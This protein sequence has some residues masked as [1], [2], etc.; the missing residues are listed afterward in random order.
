MKSCKNTSKICQK[1]LGVSI[2]L[3]I[4]RKT[5]KGLCE[6]FRKGLFCHTQE[7]LRE[8]FLILCYCFLIL[9][10]EIVS[11]TFSPIALSND[12][13]IPTFYPDLLSRPFIPTFFA[14]FGWMI[15]G[16]VGHYLLSVWL[17]LAF[18]QSN[19]KSLSV[20]NRASKNISAKEHS[21]PAILPI[22]LIPIGIF[23]SSQ[24]TFRWPFVLSPLS[25]REWFVRVSGV[26]QHLILFS[27]TRQFN[28]K[29]SNQLR[30]RADIN[31]RLPSR[32]RS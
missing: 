31:L 14:R 20:S 12:V 23:A 7:I 9:K 11:R 6:L 4:Y 21:C 27:I 18:V 17:R 29:F 8:L 10:I 25:W 15:S 28:Y 30:I 13:F 19:G 5:K 26:S 2:I 24:L 16:V 22:V 32:K 3:K 1:S